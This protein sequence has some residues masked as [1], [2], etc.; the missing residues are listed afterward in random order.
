M[1]VVI[2]Q[3]IAVDAA[4]KDVFEFLHD[5]DRRQ[6][7]DAMTDLARL[8]DATE[9]AVGVRLHLRGR[10]TAPSWVGEYDELAPPRRSVLRL[11]EGVGMPFSAFSQTIEVA[12]VKG[13]S[14]VTLRLDYQPRGLGRLLEPVVLRPRLT[15]AVRRSLASISSY[16]V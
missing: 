13:G 8:E 11:V 14:T 4:P 6:V 2:E 16:F 9:P 1:S 15:K 5:P 3:R 7:W 10:R 12:T